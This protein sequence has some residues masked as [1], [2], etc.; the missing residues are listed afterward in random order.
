MMSNANLFH[1]HEHEQ[2]RVLKATMP[3]T[4]VV[5]YVDLLP[6]VPLTGRVWRAGAVRFTVNDAKGGQ[7]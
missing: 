5:E 3:R 1:R 7:R 4:G 2:E 6:R